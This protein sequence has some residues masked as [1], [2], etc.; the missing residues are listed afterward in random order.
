MAIK[1]SEEVEFDQDDVRLVHKWG[2][3]RMLRNRTREY[4]LVGRL[5]RVLLQ[6]AG[7]RAAGMGLVVDGKMGSRT[8]I[9]LDGHN[10][11][12]VTSGDAQFSIELGPELAAILQASALTEAAPTGPLPEDPPDDESAVGS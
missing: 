7:E 4:V 11:E 10:A 9:V 3:T 2:G 12:A 1:V 6:Y 5:Q 8:R